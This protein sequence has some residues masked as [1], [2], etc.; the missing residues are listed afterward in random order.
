MKSKDH[1]NF[2]KERI[3]FSKNPLC[4]KNKIFKI[5]NYKIIRKRYLKTIFKLGFKN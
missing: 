3:V 1:T 2:P 5:N 4:K